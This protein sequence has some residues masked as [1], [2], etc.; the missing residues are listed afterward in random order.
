VGA[1]A[2][3]SFPYPSEAIAY[4]ALPS[5]NLLTV[6]SSLRPVQPG[7]FIT[8]TPDEIQKLI[9]ENRVLT[10]ENAILR[11]KLLEARDPEPIER[12][13]VR[14]VRVLISMAC[15]TLDRVKHLWRISMGNKERFFKRLRDVWEFFLQEDWSLSDLFPPTA[16]KK[17][18]SKPVCKFC[19]APIQWIKDFARYLPHNE[20]G[21]RHRCQEYRH[22][23]REEPLTPELLASVPY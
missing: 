15:C 4:V 10:E 1:R 16:E 13:T 11:R 23:N 9:E 8:M 22:R 5:I 7:R 20:D 21:S 18:R 17:Q 14:R 12:P 19:Q 3:N 6:L 2:E